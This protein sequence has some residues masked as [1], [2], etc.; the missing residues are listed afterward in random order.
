MSGE[1]WSWELPSFLSQS[2]HHWTSVHKTALEASYTLYHVCITNITQNIVLRGWEWECGAD[3][4]T[5]SIQTTLC[6][7]GHSCSLLALSS[8]H[9]HQPGTKEEQ[10]SSKPTSQAAKKRSFF[11]FESLFR[12]ESFVWKKK[13]NRPLLFKTCFLKTPCCCPRETGSITHFYSSP[14]QTMGRQWC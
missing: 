4:G 2:Q 9:T 12:S 14:R 11:F 3:R 1:G 13:K 5:V 7:L 8:H 10:G 6:R